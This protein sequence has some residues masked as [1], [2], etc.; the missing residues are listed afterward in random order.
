MTDPIDGGNDNPYT[1]PADPINNTDTSGLFA[2]ALPLI[3]LGPIGWAVLAVA[4]AATLGAYAYSRRHDLADG[5]RVLS[6]RINVAARD[7]AR[8]VPRAQR[9]SF[10]ATK[11]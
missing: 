11:S 5:W 4:A 10:R 2:A 6:S 3:A 9:T 1:Y 8:A 7:A